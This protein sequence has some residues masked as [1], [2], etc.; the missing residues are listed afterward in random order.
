MP[1]AQ[2]DYYDHFSKVAEKAVQSAEY[3]L[4][5][6][7]HFDP[8]QVPDWAREMHK[9]ENDADMLKH[10]MLQNLAHEFIAPIEREDIVLLAE[11][12]DSCVDQLEDV[13]QKLY[14]FSTETIRSEALTF[15]DMLVKCAKA[16]R[17]ATVEFKNFKKSRD[18]IQRIIEVNTV[19]SDGDHLYMESMH[20][21]YKE[22]KDARELITWTTIFDALEA[23]LDGMEDTADTIE[24][25]IMKN[26]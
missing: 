22:E 21:L 10:E 16:L 23:S 9:I 5:A 6:L 2:F 19:E 3:L 24:S 1:R 20:R 13:M 8:E 26:S 12:L 15:A 17:Q 14:M 7:N 18:V 11:E 4:H 25:I